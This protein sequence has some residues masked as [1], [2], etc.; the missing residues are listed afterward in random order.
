MKKTLLSSLALASFIT[1]GL[2]ENTFTTAKASEEIQ[3]E[4][5][6]AQIQYYDASGKKIQPYSKDEL[7]EMVV[8]KALSNPLESAMSLSSIGTY[9]TYEKKKIGKTSF[10]HNVWIGGG[11][12]GEAYENPIDL[13]ITPEGES[14]A[15]HIIVYNDK[16]NK[17]AGKEVGRIEVPAGLYGGIH[18]SWSHLKR[19]KKYRFELVNVKASTKNK[20]ELKSGVLLYD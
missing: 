17:R 7:K 16:E 12:W 4:K 19:G 1:F 13:Q 3:K 8:T 15:I 9:E 11:L 6:A 5:I 10:S 20:Y 14:R 2:L 18:M